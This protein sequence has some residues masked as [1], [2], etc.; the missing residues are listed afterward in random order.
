LIRSLAL[1][2]ALLL[3]AYTAAQDQ[4]V[5]LVIDTDGAE[6]P[7]VL[8]VISDGGVVRTFAGTYVLAP[9]PGTPPTEPTDPTPPEAP[10]ARGT[11]ERSVRA[12]VMTVPES[13]RDI[14]FD[15]GATYRVTAR[16]V[17]T[18]RFKNPT[19]AL[20]GLRSYVL[21]TLGDQLDTWRSAANAVVDAVAAEVQSTGATTNEQ[22][23]AILRRAGRTMET[24]RP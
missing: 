17:S 11:L 24:M 3:P 22:V 10:E 5:V 16:W 21:A 9:A 2:S 6:T 19:E 4:P 15:L 20:D 14:R 18:G 7:A 13:A 8:V 12:A 23:S 1:L